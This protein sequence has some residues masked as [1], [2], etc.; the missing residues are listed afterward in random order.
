MSGKFDTLEQ[1]KQ[2]EQV[3]NRHRLNKAQR[4]DL[5]WVC[6]RGNQFSLR[7]DSVHQRSESKLGLAQSAEGLNARLKKEVQHTCLP[8]PAPNPPP[9]ICVFSSTVLLSDAFQSSWPFTSVTAREVTE[10]PLAFSHNGK[11]SGLFRAVLD[12]GSSVLRG[13]ISP[14]PEMLGCREGLLHYERGRIHPS[15][16][17][18]F[19]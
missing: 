14:P 12:S 2:N 7:W 9:R 10:A 19:S 8:P 5:N 15:S 11:D 17:E 6:V 18:Y 4:Q 1:S 3:P 13:A 16:W